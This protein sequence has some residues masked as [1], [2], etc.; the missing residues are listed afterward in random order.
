[1]DAVLGATGATGADKVGTLDRRIGEAGARQTHG[2]P[3]P[4]ALNEGADTMPGITCTVIGTRYD[5]TSTP[6]EATF[7]TI[8]PGPTVDN[9]PYG[10]GARR[11]GQVTG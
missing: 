8:G 6:Y 3:L 11:T 2:S 5:R 4:T 10:T 1:M 9:S 7:L